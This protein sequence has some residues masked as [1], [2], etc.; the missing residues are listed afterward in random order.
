[1]RDYFHTLAERLGA[2]L[3]GNELFTLSLTGEETDFA[4]FNQA[5]VRQAGHVRQTEARLE[6]IEGGRHGVLDYELQGHLDTDL[7]RLE[8][9]LQDLR[10]LLPHLPEDPHLLYAQEVHDSERLDPSPLPDARAIT[11]EVLAAARGLDLVGIL[12][13]GRQTWGFANSLGQRNWHESMS[14]HLDWSAYLAGDKAVKAVYAGNAWSSEAF[15]QRLEDMRRQL[16][17]MARPPIHLPPGD[18]RAYL[19]PTALRELLEMLAWEGFGL[20]SHR[21][22]ET[23]LIR[24]VREGAR[25]SPKVTLSEDAAEGIAPRFTE[26][27]FIRPE[28]VALIEG[29]AYRDCLVSPRSAM[30][31][32]ATVTGEEYPDSLRLEPGDLPRDRALQELER[33]LLINNLWYCN[34]SDPNHCRITGMT[35]FACF[36]VDGGEIQAP[37]QVLRFDDSLY[38]MLGSELLDLTREQDLLL[39]GDTYGGR[40]STSYRL[41]GALL[42]SLRFTL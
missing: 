36:W 21:T 14:F 12:A 27:G 10:G 13:A 15:A 25:L 8:G 19:A 1:M 23:P 34:F 3:Q 2:S 5:R 39:D 33:G 24:M 35:R 30:E 6:L 7:A 38:R 22:A 11:A 4:R 41:P 37:V 31:Y 28:R 9:G 32:G 18:Y 29:G 42:K 26:V 40:S 20:K 16:A 17:V